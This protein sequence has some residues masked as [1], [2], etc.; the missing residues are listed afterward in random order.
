LTAQRARLADGRLHLNHGPIDLIIEAFGAGS[1]IEAA[2]DQAW[3]RFPAILP[4]LAGELGLLR[5]PI[6]VAMPAL[7]SPVARRMA[8]AVWP[9]RQHFIT[10]MAAVAGAV[11]EEVLAAM[12]QG[13]DLAKAYVNNGGDIALHL[14]PDERFS[15]GIVAELAAPAIAGR[16][17]IAASDAVRGIATSG[18]GGRSFSLGIADAVTVLA[19][20]AADADAA[21]TMIANAVDLDHPAI[22][23]RP[24]SSLDPDSDLE[25]LPVTV[26]VGELSPGEIAAALDL[27]AARAMEYARAGLILAAMLQLRGIRR[28]VSSDG[29]SHPQIS[30]HR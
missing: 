29:Y 1:E 30:R 6:G 15:I 9:F 14:A 18:Q 17:E 23:R 22:Q 16:A 19:R 27:G 20:R 5:R 25:E 3:Q 8:E 26:A 7:E 28:I 12:T 11:A 4:E 21:A 10:P 24:A 2:Y 13:R